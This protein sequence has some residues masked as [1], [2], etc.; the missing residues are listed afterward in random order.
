[1]TRLATQ[2]EQGYLGRNW[3]AE[4]GGYQTRAIAPFADF[5]G[6]TAAA[7]AADW[8]QFQGDGRLWSAALPAS[9]SS[10]ATRGN[11]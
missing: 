11:R 8:Q 1:M 10:S 2:P 5:P 3:D 4:K 9:P 6:D 7:Y